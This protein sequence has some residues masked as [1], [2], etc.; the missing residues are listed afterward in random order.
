MKTPTTAAEAR[1]KIM[2]ARKRIE[3]ANC[4]IHEL[5]KFIESQGALVKPNNPEEE[6]GSFMLCTWIVRSRR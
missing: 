5:K 3:K 6:T 4:D 2:L 1:Y